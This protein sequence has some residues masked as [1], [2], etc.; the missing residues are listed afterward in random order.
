[1]AR[2]PT[3]LGRGNCASRGAKVGAA[4]F[5]A[6]MGEFRW[7]EKERDER[8]DGRENRKRAK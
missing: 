8:E 7:D 4:I 2:I 1:M 3:S 5:V 6:T